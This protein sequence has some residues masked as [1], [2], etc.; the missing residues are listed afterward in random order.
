M[1]VLSLNGEWKFG[2]TTEAERLPVQIPGSVLSGLLDNKKIDD[3]F[4]RENEYKTRDLFLK[5]YTFERVFELS[6]EMMAED[7]MDLVCEGLDTIADIFLNGVKLAHTENMH[8]TYR[9]S[10][11]DF[12]GALKVGENKLVI[13]FASPLKYI[14]EYEAT[15]GKEI[16]NIPAGC[17]AGNQYLRKAHCMFGWDWGANLPDCGI[18]RDIKLEAYSEIR[19]DRVLTKQEHTDGKV[20]LTVSTLFAKP[21]DKNYK[22]SVT[23]QHAWCGTK[24]VYSTTAQTRSVLVNAGSDRIDITYE[25][26]EPKL[27]WPNDQGEQNLYDVDISLKNAGF[28]GGGNAATEINRQKPL[29]EKHLTIGLRTL[30]VSME[31]DEWGREFAFCVNGVKIFSMGGDYIPEDNVLSRVNT[32]VREHLIKSAARAHYNT[33]R[34]WGGGYY[35]SDEFYDL[36]D[37]YGLIVW[38]D[39]MYACNIYD[40]TEEFRE[41]II[42]ETVDNVRR[43]RHHASLGLWCGNNEMESAWMDWGWSDSHS[44]YLKADYIKM[45]EEIL[46]RVVNE[47]DGVTMYWPSSPSS[48]GCFNNPCDENSGDTHYWDVWHG[49]KPFSDYLKYYFRYCSEFGFQS[50]PAMKTIESFTEPEDR[51]IFSPVMENHQKNDS[52]NGKILYY[53]SENFR[54]PKDF[55]QLV[56]TSQILQA[57]AIKAGVEH[58]RRNRGRCMGA[59]YWQINDNWPVAS[60]SSIDYFGRW[61]AMHYLAEDFF[62]PVAGSILK[63]GE[64]QGYFSGV[65]AWIANETAS[66][67]QAKVCIRLKDMNFNVLGEVRGEKSVG[68]YSSLMICEADYADKLVKFKSEYDGVKLECKDMCGNGVGGSCLISPRNVFVEAE[69]EI[70]SENG[71]V[72]RFTRTEV[73]APHKYMNLPKVCPEVCVS[74]NEDSFEIALTCSGYAPFV[75][76]ELDGADGIFSDNFFDL[77]SREEYSVTL[78]KKDIF[79]G[80]IASSDALRQA[81]QI[82]IL[83]DTYM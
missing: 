31:K 13:N 21:A 71:E 9:I 10:L 4:Y 48:G 50:L 59:V 14:S 64:K 56:Y 43:L 46:P 73:L 65:Q 37:K 82:N 36:C 11:N 6:E 16:T 78:A 12:P 47:E 69:F 24:R 66:K 35:P 1:K 41:N 15:P 7:Y 33:M 25:I 79:R 26:E 74:E 68:A 49:Q 3:P 19:I 70:T 61:K 72:T 54:Y 52:A 28:V 77:S 17:A 34:V 83:Q 80:E 45:Y 30:K 20:I 44:A 81:L 63:T 22:L 23:V 18:W 55:A 75:Y 60:W 76:L 5:D 62:A 27:W 32:Q 39:L 2:E 58:W 53:L 40:L 8:R 51:N 29:Q 67:V 38:Q 57:I 42:A